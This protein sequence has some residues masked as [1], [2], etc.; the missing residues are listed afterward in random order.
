MFRS[1]AL[2][3]GGVR[4]GLH[5]GGLRAL[6]EHQPLEFPDGIYGCSIGSIIATAIAFRITVDQ[7]ETMLFKDFVLSSFIPPVTLAS[8]LSFQ[9]KKGMFSMDMLEETIVRGF[10]RCGVDLRGKVIADAPQK[11]SIL[12]SNLT[13]RKSTFF[14]GQVPILAALKASSCIPFVY[15]PQVIYNQVFLDGGVS[16][17]CIVSVVP[18]DTLVFHIGYSQG[19][20]VPSVM[21][22][23][24]IADFFRNVYASVREGLRPSFSNVLNFTEERL[25]PLSDVKDTDKTYMLETGYEQ[26]S[27]FFAK[28]GRQ[29]RIE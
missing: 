16:C 13:T 17:D 28:I 4:G 19:P 1:I 14:T 23:M 21:E 7:L 5:I 15:Q 6:S 26:A 29:K 25:G 20:I 2:G 27:R 9:S 3:G 22:N 8:A 11:L 10:N 24:Q 12:A 18:R